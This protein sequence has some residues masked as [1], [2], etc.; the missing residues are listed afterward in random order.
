MKEFDLA[1]GLTTAQMNHRVRHDIPTLIKLINSQV[2]S[3]E[4]KTLQF[5][6]DGFVEFLIQFAHL[7]LNLADMP[8][9]PTQSYKYKAHELVQQTIKMIASANKSKNLLLSKKYFE[10]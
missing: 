10:D 4:I 3:L 5:D 8:D 6:Y 2:F 9:Y 1:P 7:N